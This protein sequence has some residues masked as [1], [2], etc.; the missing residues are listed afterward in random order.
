MVHQK[1]CRL[2]HIGLSNTGLSD[3]NF[4]TL[5]AAITE[6][7]SIGSVHVAHNA[8]NHTSQTREAFKWCLRGNKTL[9]FLDLSYNRFTVES[10]KAIYLAVLENDVLNILRLVGNSACAAEEYRL[11]QD[12]LKKNRNKA[13]GAE[14]FDTMA[15]Y[16]AKDGDMAA[17]YQTRA[18]GE[19]YSIPEADVCISTDTTTIPCAKAEY[20][21]ESVRNVLC[22][23]FSAPLAWKDRSRKLHGIEMLDYASEREMLW[24]LLKEVQRDI[25]VQFDF[26]TTDKLR[27]AVTLGCRGS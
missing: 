12:K 11:L 18:D 1:Y 13:S 27:T 15:F 25:E 5:L 22:V 6:N 16:N 4:T 23:L 7:K 10:A 24:Q 20:A 21:V 9:K 2:R 14:D 8:L 19:T 17:E 3:K 26:A